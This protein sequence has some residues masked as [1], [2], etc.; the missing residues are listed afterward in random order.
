MG[1]LDHQA[2]A[3][4][5]LA[6]GILAGAMLQF[7]HDLQR[8]VY[9]IIGLYPLNADHRADTAGVMLKFGVVHEADLLLL[10][11]KHPES[12]H[13]KDFLRRQ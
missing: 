11:F 4:A 7:F 12:P 10:R 13:K 9:G 8:P 6:G 5:H 2:Y 1:H 3:I